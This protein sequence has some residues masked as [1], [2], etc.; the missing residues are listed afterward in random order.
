MP[1]PQVRIESLPNLGP[2]SAQMLEAAGIRTLTQLRRHGAAK[3]YARVKAIDSR[4]S[5]NLLWAM[6]AALSGRTWQD[7]ARK[8][9]L[10]LLLAVEDCAQQPR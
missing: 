5:L 7:V 9:R 3:A 4:A 1:K 8:D 6:E 2:R 10:R